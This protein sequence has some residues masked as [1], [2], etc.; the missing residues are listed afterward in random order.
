[1]QPELLLWPSPQRLRWLNGPAFSPHGVQAEASVRPTLSVDAYELHWEDGRLHYCARDQ[2]GLDNAHATWLQICERCGPNDLLDPLDILDAPWFTLRGVMLD[3]SRC[4]IPTREELRRIVAAVAALKG[5]HLQLYVEHSVAYPGHDA[6]TGPASAMSLEELAELSAYAGGLGVELAV[7]QNCL[8]HAE[9]WLA[10]PAYAHLGEFGDV[11]A[12]LA[13]GEPGPFSFCPVDPRCL[14]LVNSWVAAQIAAV[15]SRHVHLGGD[16]TVDIGLGRSRSAV[17]QRG[18]GKLWGDYMARCCAPVLAAGRIPLVWA[19]MALEHPQAF[20]ALPAEAIALA[21]HYEA[22][23][24]MA[25]WAQ[26]F[27]ELG[28]PWWVC[29]GTSA[30]RSWVGRGDARRGSIGAALRHGLPGGASGML[31]TDW[32]DLGHRQ[33][34]PVSWYGLAEGLGAAWAGPS[35]ADQPAVDRALGL[36]ALGCAAAGPW[37]D[38]LSRLEVSL[39]RESQH[40]LRGGPLINASLPFVDTLL[41]WPRSAPECLPDLGAWEDL[42]QAY[43]SYPTAPAGH[44]ADE[45]NHGLAAVRLACT[46]AV[47]RRRGSS[48]QALAPSWLQLS[49][50]HAAQWQRRCRPGGLAESCGFYQRLAAEGDS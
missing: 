46:R 27:A 14:P 12:R 20:A 3:I 13:A 45:L 16:E 40:P 24:P 18:L 37:L 1:M 41:P 7:H 26:T 29:P 31:V 39:R 23:G 6:V 4:R 10:H 9:R 21:W 2:R 44:L 34:W 17:Q 38:Q 8:G 42:L 5:N 28:R 30:W 36:R 11:A 35:Y 19:D 22:E 43:E 47:A 15:P 49:A 32:G 50:Q 33:P 48:A 25:R